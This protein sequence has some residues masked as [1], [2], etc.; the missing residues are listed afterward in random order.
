MRMSLSECSFD[1]PCLGRAVSAVALLCGVSGHAQNGVEL[2]RNGTFD[3]TIDGW[4][5]WYAVS[6]EARVDMATTER[7]IRA[8]VSWRL[9]PGAGGG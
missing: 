1:W 5:S 7:P 6:F 3:T 4:A 2:L 8:G 9:V